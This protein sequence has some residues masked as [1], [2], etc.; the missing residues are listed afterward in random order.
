[1]ENPIAQDSAFNVLALDG[2]GARG[3]YSAQILACI[4]QLNGAPVREHFD[5][6]A[7]TSTGAIIAGAAAVGIPMDRVVELFK[8]ESPRIFRKRRLRSFYIRSKYSIRS[9]EQAVQSCV[10]GL[11]LDEVST[12]LMILGS[13]ISTGG[14]H[15]FKSRYLKD[16]G[17][18]YV[19]DANIV[20]SDA[21]LAS[22]A[23][24]TFFDPVSVGDFL[25]ADGGLWANNP[26]MMALTESVSKFGRS[27]EQVRILSIG[28]GHSVN[29]Y[30]HSRLWGFITGWGREKLVSYV[31]RL[32]SDASAN[33][34]KLLLADRYLRIDP[35]IEA[36]D[37]DDIEHLDNLKAL[38][39]RDFTVLSKAIMKNLNKPK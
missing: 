10:S 21:I 36:W 12:P 29:L 14:V 39:A 22:C 38:A 16:L 2:G 23:A 18:P 9:L 15:V 30:S 1:M 37:L 26:S 13:D 8:D 35:E 31:M 6:I 5:L 32:Q 24:P 20:L 34:A 19:R 17:E 4:E 25:L 33:M 27:I 11:T 28:T 3:I 7:G